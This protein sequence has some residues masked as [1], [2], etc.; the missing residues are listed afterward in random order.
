MAQA[1]YYLEPPVAEYPLMAYERAAEIAEAG[2]RYA[3]EK[4]GQW[5]RK[6]LLL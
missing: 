6:K 2:Y 4:I 1:N 3:T 5:D